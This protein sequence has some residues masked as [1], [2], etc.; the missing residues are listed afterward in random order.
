[1][2]AV[3]DRFE[4]E[5]AVV[6]LGDKEVK[7]DVLKKHLPSGVREGD[8]LKVTFEIDRQG[9]KEQEKKIGSLLERLKNKNT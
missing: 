2:K 1:M 5:Y 8:W 3:I 7:I 6:L 9:T 4:G